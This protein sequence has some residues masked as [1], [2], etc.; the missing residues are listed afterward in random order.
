MGHLWGRYTNCRIFIEFYKWDTSGAVTQTAQFLSNF[1]N[2]TPLE[3]LH[4]LSNFYQI[5]QMGHL[6]DRYTNCRIL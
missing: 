2:G 5:L 6:W 1:T 4:K 3:P